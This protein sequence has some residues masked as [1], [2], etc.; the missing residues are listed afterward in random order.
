VGLEPLLDEAVERAWAVV[1]D[2][3]RLQVAGI[4]LD[5]QEKRRIAET[6]GIGAIK[7]ADLS[8]NRT[9]DYVFD[10]DKMVRME[11]NTSTYIQYSY[12]RTQSILRKAAEKGWSE[13]SWSEAP[14]RLEAPVELQLGLQLA[15]YEELLQQSMQDYTPNLIT[16]YLFDTARLFSSFF[17]QCPVLRADTE[18]EAY[19][20]LKLTALVGKTLRSGL[21]LLGIDVIDRM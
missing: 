2:P 10:M 1:C 5:D 8:H 11:G 3:D 18:S 15:R 6:V 9:S 19:S 21:G 20:R 13:S 12:A 16:E 17:E 7:Y 4:E 14:L